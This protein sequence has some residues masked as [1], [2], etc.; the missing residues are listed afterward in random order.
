[1]DQP[2]ATGSW[3]EI[4]LQVLKRDNYRCVS[5]STPV[6]SAEADVHHL[7]PR[8]MGGTDELSNLVTLCD[9]CHAVQHQTWLVALRGGLLSDGRSGLPVGWI[10][11]ARFPKAL[12]ISARSS[13]CSG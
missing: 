8:S 12:A 2:I 13:V 3:Q 7:L 11:K 6:K 1:M 9:G 4:R 5:C 10:L